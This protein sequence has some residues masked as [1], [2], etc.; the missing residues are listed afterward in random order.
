MHCDVIH[1]TLVFNIGELDM[2]KF[3]FVLLVAYG[4]GV[5]VSYATYSTVIVESNIKRSLLW[6]M[7]V[8]TEVLVPV[9]RWIRTKAVGDLHG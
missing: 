4:F 1:G 8:W 2:L 3:L 7:D 6:F 9:A 5:L